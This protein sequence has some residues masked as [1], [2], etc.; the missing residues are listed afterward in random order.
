M[1]DGGLD[2]GRVE[3]RY[4]KA[5]CA[6]QLRQ[7]PMKCARK[8]QKYAHMQEISRPRLEKSGG[9]FI[10]QKAFF[11]LLCENFVNFFEFPNYP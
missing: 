10:K 8:E 11:E 3:N 6:S 4:E 2:D 7:L 1:A 5:V 9:Y